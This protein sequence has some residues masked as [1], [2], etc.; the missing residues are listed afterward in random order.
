MKLAFMD[1][2]RQP[3]PTL[4]RC[5]LMVIEREKCGLRTRRHRP[6]DPTRSR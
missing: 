2:G 3:Q 1:G 5:G 4:H 6:D